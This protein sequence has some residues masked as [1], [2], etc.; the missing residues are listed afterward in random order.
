MLSDQVKKNI[1]GHLTGPSADTSVLMVVAFVEKNLVEFSWQYTGSSITNERGLNQQ[2]CI[3]LNRYAYNENYPF[4]FDKDHME[5]PERGDSPSVDIGV[6]SSR[7]EGIKISAKC[8]SNRESFFSMEAKRLC[9]ISEARQK[10]Y[11]IGRMEKGKYKE[12]GGVERFKKNI[13]G[14]RLKYG[15]MIGYVQEQNF[16]YWHKTINSWI[17]ELIIE[18]IGNSIRWTEK[19]KLS[20]IYKHESTAKFKSENARKSGSI[21]LF[22]L[23]V[24]LV[25]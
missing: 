18:T 11:L 2:L 5:E 22:H 3:L 20:A 4:W 1:S 23:W 12:R 15:A 24:N 7:D 6:L 10:E 25:K 17:D 14:K 21:I 9:K 13:H 16:E 19:D 8:Y